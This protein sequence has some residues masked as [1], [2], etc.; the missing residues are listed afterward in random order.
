[1]SCGYVCSSE[2][3]VSPSLLPPPR[4]CHVQLTSLQ[5][6]LPMRLHPGA[7]FAA[8][9]RL[10]TRFLHNQN[11]PH[12]PNSTTVQLVAK[13]NESLFV[14]LLPLLDVWLVGH[15]T[16]CRSHVEH[17]SKR[18]FGTFPTSDCKHRCFRCIKARGRR[19][20]TKRRAIGLACTCGDSSRIHVDDWV[21]VENNGALSVSSG[22]GSK[23]EDQRHGHHAPWSWRYGKR[24]GRRAACVGHAVDQVGVSHGKDA[25]SHD[26]HGRT[27]ASLVR[28]KHGNAFLGCQFD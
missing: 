13:G 8:C 5:C 6:P 15:T 20:K 24:M 17:V 22:G 23:H 7:P 19:R 4:R 1:M 14:R 11:A 3:F 25:T 26:Q 21:L 28:H 10:P 27:N 12:V 18:H 9:L 2:P 16:T